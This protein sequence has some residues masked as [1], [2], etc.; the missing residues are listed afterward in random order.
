[1]PSMHSSSTAD[2]SAGTRAGSWNP[3]LLSLGG[4]LDGTT[5]RFRRALRRL[6]LSGFRLISVSEPF[7]TPAVGCE[8]GAPDFTNLSVLGEWDGTPLELLELIH[9]IEREEGR[10]ADHPRWHSRTLDIDIILMGV[11]R[12][13]E[14]ELQIPHPLASVRDF[15]MIPSKQILPPGLFHFLEMSGT[16]G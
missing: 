13:N 10:P 2:V 7:V 9:Q 15:V 16:R 5:E 3:V 12:V 6:S 4:N 8:P 14:P 11:E 1:M